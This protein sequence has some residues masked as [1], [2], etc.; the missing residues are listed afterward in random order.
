LVALEDLAKSQ[1]K[2]RWSKTTPESDHVRNIK[3]NVENPTN[4]VD[5]FHTK[6]INGAYSSLF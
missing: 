5:S 4:F 3:W 2:G 6:P 1:G